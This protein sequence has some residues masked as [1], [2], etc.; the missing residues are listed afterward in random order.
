MK[1]FLLREESLGFCQEANQS[2][3][4]RSEKKIEESIS[5]ENIEDAIDLKNRDSFSTRKEKSV[6]YN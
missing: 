1:S 6:L 4:P 3:D 2:N 5:K